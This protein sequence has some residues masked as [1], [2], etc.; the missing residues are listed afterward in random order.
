[1]RVAARRGFFM[2]HS[3]LA[4]CSILLFESKAHL[5]RAAR[6]ALEGAG[7]HVFQASTVADALRVIEEVQL[8]V[9]VLDYTRSIK[10]GHPISRRLVALNV[11]LVFCK[12]IGR[13]EAW[14]HAPVLSRPVNFDELIETLRRLLGPETRALDAPRCERSRESVPRHSEEPWL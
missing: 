13:N 6:K 10:E 7:A 3:T 4:G 8:S 9:A 14:P 2:Q 5:S 1:M 11:P 12:D